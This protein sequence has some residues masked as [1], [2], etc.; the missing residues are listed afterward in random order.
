LKDEAQK[1]FEKVEGQVEYRLMFIVA[2][3]AKLFQLQSE[4]DTQIL[5]VINLQSHNSLID[6]ISVALVE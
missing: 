2:R 6:L 4:F 3:E 1:A 5:S